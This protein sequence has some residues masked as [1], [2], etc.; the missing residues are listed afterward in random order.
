MM[1]KKAQHA[2]N[3]EAK[4]AAKAAKAAAELAR[5]QA[6]PIYAAIAPQ[7]AAAV[8]QAGAAVDARLRE[9]AAKLVG[10]DLRETAPRASLKIHGYGTRYK[11]AQ[12][13]HNLA[14]AIVTCRP[15]ADW[16]DDS[17]HVLAVNEAGIARLVADAEAQAGA[18]FDGYVAKLTEKVGECDSAAV[19]GYLWQYSHLTVNKG[20]VVEV[21][22]TQQI[23]NVS[24]LGTLFNQ[25]PTRKV[26][27]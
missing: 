15:R 13:F 25:W 3:M 9:I 4:A 1:T 12:A 27:G 19:V 17:Q 20:A 18:S 2:A 24:V 11:Q 23:V 26:K 21:W 5:I 22:K 7:K 16:R 14:C 6:N 10:T 8:A